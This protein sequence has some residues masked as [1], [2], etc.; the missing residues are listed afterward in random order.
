MRCQ[1]FLL[2]LSLSAGLTAFAQVQKSIERPPINNLTC[3][4]ETSEEIP[5]CEYRVKNIAIS[6]IPKLISDSQLLAFNTGFQAPSEEFIAFPKGNQVVFKISDPAKR[7]AFIRALRLNDTLDN[8]DNIAPEIKITLKVFAIESSGYDNLEAGLSA[9]SRSKNPSDAKSVRFDTESSFATDGSLKTGLKLNLGNLT[10]ALFGLHLDLTRLSSWSTDSEVFETTVTNG[11]NI[12]GNSSTKTYNKEVSSISAVENADIG[13]SL[14]G[15]VSLDKTGTRMSI[16]NFSVRH[17]AETKEP[18]SIATETFINRPSI[19]LDLDK[20]YVIAKRSVQLDAS[21]RGRNFI[22]AGKKSEK[23]VSSDLIMVISASR[24]E[25]SE[26]PVLQREREQN[27]GVELVSNPNQTL[28][29]ALSAVEGSVINAEDGVLSS[30]LFG[31]IAGFRIK[32]SALSLELADRMVYVK[33]KNMISGEVRSTP[34]RLRDLALHGSRFSTLKYASLQES[35]QMRSDGCKIIPISIQI[36]EDERSAPVVSYIMR[37]FPEQ[38]E[39]AIQ[40]AT[41][42]PQAQNNS[43]FFQRLLG[44][45]KK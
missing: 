13:F 3:T 45:N 30:S 11:E 41:S 21:S 1:F 32:P 9:F 5:V 31:Q 23:L 39:V 37:Y 8:L 34:A 35:C 28:R 18:N 17:A 27:A 19:V 20:P 7:D 25:R 43:G 36:S 4:T 10:S 22:F 24:V 6:Q 16:K 14:S 26:F 29:Q 40:S 12:P 15:R 44:G 42:E 2:G 38:R 33:E